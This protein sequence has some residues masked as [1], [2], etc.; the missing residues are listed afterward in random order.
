M[1][2]PE[3]NH[4]SHRS[5]DL[6]FFLG[7]SS[8]LVSHTGHNRNLTV[9][10]SQLGQC[11]TGTTSSN[12]KYEQRDQQA[13]CHANQ[14]SPADSVQAHRGFLSRQPRQAV[15]RGELPEQPNHG[16]HEDEPADHPS[17]KFHLLRTGGGVSC[18]EPYEAARPMPAK[19]N[20]GFVRALTKLSALANLR[21]LPRLYGRSTRRL[22]SRALR[23]KTSAPVPAG[24]PANSNLLA[25]FSQPFSTRSPSARRRRPF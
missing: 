25:S 11:G 19:S 5:S 10:P 23:E 3:A 17:Q 9:L 22:A 1:T 16:C 12:R 14:R 7:G 24:C 18:M 21:W 2:P 4:Q 20:D 15:A 13:D 6:F 8:C